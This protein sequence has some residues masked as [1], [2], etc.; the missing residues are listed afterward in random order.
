MQHSLKYNVLKSEYMV[1]KVRSKC[2]LQAPSILFHSQQLKSVT[3]F[4][5]L[6]ILLI[7]DLRDDADIQTQS[8]SDEG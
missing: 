7:N 8:I 4:K 2:P 6:G 1:F 5:Y 3:S